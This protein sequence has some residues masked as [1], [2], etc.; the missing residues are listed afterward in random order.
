M[1][2]Y[3]QPIFSI[4]DLDFIES[5]KNAFGSMV[6]A[7]EAKKVPMNITIQYG[8]NSVKFIFIKNSIT[9][10]PVTGEYTVDKYTSVHAQ[11][12]PLYQAFHNILIYGELSSL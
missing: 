5:I 9:G 1:D 12:V 2:F 8:P 4:N 10:N 6:Y 7:I 11:M 3:T